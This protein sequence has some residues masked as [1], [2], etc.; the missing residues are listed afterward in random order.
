MNRRERENLLIEGQNLLKLKEAIQSYI[1]ESNNPCPNEE[2]L[3]SS[4]YYLNMFYNNVAD[5]ILG[6]IKRFDG[7]IRK[8]LDIK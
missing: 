5:R 4:L 8:D 1:V 3:E 6:D 2:Q 7:K